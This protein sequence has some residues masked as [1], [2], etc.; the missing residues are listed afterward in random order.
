MRSRFGLLDLFPSGGLR[1]IRRRTARL[2][3]LV[4]LRQAVGAGWIVAEVGAGENGV[5]LAELDGVHLV[6]STE[7]P[8]NW[9]PADGLESEILI[10]GVGL[11]PGRG[12][13]SRYLRL[14]GKEFC[15]NRAVCFWR[16]GQGMGVSI[17]GICRRG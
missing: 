1:G 16:L 5:G 9:P 8:L 6:A 7:A 10:Q 11:I 3:L 13:R 2:E 12:S 15:E 14:V 17:Q 4:A